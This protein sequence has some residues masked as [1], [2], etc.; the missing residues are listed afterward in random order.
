MYIALY[1]ADQDVI[2]YPFICLNGEQT[3]ASKLD[4]WQGRKGLRGRTGWIIRSQQPRLVSTIEE[5]AAW[6]D[7]MGVEGS[8][9]RD[10]ASWLGAPMVY[11]DQALGVIAAFHLTDEHKYSEDDLEVIQI[12]ASQAAVALQNLRFYQAWMQELDKVNADYR[13]AV[14]SDVGSEFAHRMNNLA[15]TIP[16]WV[17]MARAL[18]DRDNPRDVQVLEYL[19]KVD[20]DVK[21]LI[22][23]AQVI[24]KTTEKRPPETIKVNE[25]VEIA[26]G[27]A[28]ETLPAIEKRI[29]I[30]KHLASDLPDLELEREKLLD[31]LTSI[32]KNGLEAMPKEGILTVSTRRSGGVKAPIE[33]QVTDT[34]IGIPP[35][36]LTKIFDLFFTT[37]GKQGLGYGLWRDKTFIKEL[38]GD[39]DVDSQ[40]SEGTT[41]TIKIPST[42]VKS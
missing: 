22:Q 38:G 24:K 30:K 32:I 1:D 41:I 31:T 27:R 13:L 25:L 10:F 39:I 40:V 20:K 34:G 11:G 18:L 37:K 6:Y 21:N 16:V 2:S 28:V 3:D 4:A 5:A 35:S 7:E 15:G 42:T 33:I 26:I 14:M 9:R 17:N 23:A 19:D 29:T 12:L 8:H 36:D